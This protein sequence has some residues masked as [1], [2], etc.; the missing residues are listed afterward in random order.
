MIKEIAFIIRKEAA[1]RNTWGK[2]RGSDSKLM[3]EIFNSAKR[4]FYGST[5]L[6]KEKSVT[7]GTF[8]IL[9]YLSLYKISTFL[10]TFVLYYLMPLKQMGSMRNTLYENIKQST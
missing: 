7:C 8:S 1:P 10:S 4:P 2:L 6:I 3:V 9:F 5:G